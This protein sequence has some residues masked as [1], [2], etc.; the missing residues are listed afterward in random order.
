MEP[1]RLPRFKRCLNIRPIRLTER[2]V[3]LLVWT[4]IHR[5][6]TSVHLR[7][8]LSPGSHQN[9]LR[10]LCLLYH[11]GF[12]E[13]PRTQ[14]D[15]FH[16]GGSRPMVYTLTPLGARWVEASYDVLSDWLRHS[17]GAPWGRRYLEHALAVS[18]ILVALFRAGDALNDEVRVL[19][20][21]QLDFSRSEPRSLA[22]TVDAGPFGKLSVIPDRV[23]QLRTFTDENESPERVTCFIEADRGTM[24]VTRRDNRQSSILRKLIAYETSWRKGLLQKRYPTD[25]FRVLIVTTNPARVE[26]MVKACQQLKCGHGLFLFTDHE[27]FAKHP[28]VYSLTFVN[29]RGEKDT[30]LTHGVPVSWPYY[31]RNA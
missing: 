2:D 12:L 30:L 18:D 3:S 29:G 23:V 19:Y 13:R 4:G 16:R 9:L 6:L 25:R 20:E 7:T 21:H 11:H 31:M 14:I 26:Q 24:P 10:R 17:H 22:W 8:L 27:T 5:V 15:Y 1:A 28:N